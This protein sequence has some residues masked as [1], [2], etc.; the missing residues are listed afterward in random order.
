VSL[1]IVIARSSPAMRVGI[2]A[3]IA[4]ITMSN[5]P[6][7]LWESQLKRLAFICALIFF[8]AAIGEQRS[9]PALPEASSA[10]A[11][12]SQDS[13]PAP[14]LALLHLLASPPA[15]ISARAAAPLSAPP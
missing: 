9:A 15:R 2:A 4:A 13:A 1:Y 5:F 10:P 11:A 8:F 14:P 3:A 6:R 7:R 12:P